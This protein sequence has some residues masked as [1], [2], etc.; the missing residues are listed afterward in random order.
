[1][2]EAKL[3]NGQ[4]I[5]LY[6]R[7]EVAKMIGI[8]PM[9]LDKLVKAGKLTGRKIGRSWAFTEE[10]ITAYLCPQPGE[11]DRPLRREKRGKKAELPTIIK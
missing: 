11:G 5:K 9:T 3:P 6:D 2:R 10:A 7:E 1:M 4:T 8:N